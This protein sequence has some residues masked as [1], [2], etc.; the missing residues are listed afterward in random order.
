LPNWWKNSEEWGNRPG[1]DIYIH[2]YIHGLCC[3]YL[4]QCKM[5]DI[6]VPWFPVFSGYN[7]V[8]ITRVTSMLTINWLYSVFVWVSYIFCNHSS[9]FFLR[10]MVITFTYLAFYKLPDAFITFFINV[11]TVSCRSVLLYFSSS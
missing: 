2:L 8:V 6:N 7:I 3:H 10:Q 1:N 9:I 4:Y 5:C 11:T